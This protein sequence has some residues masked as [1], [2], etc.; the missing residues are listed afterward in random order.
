[1]PPPDARGQSRA[2]A[3]TPPAVPAGR[4]GP[5]S[6]P[7]S[8]RSTTPYQHGDPAGTGGSRA[9]RLRKLLI[10]VAGNV[11]RQG[12]QPRLQA[13][14]PYRP[15]H[16]QDERIIHPCQEPSRS[17]A[18]RRPRR[19]FR[20]HVHVEVPADNVD[21][22]ASGHAPAS[23]R[24]VILVPGHA[25]VSRPTGAPGT[26]HRTR[27]HRLRSRTGTHKPAPRPRSSN[28]P[29]HQ[30]RRDSLRDRVCLG[31]PSC[32]GI[33]GTGSSGT[34]HSAHDGRIPKQDGRRKRGTSARGLAWARRLP[35]RPR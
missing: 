13:V 16:L 3:A 17:P 25:P 35:R 33:P 15:V 24:V 19:T 29:Y 11:R 21:I 31:F 8:S 32:D 2:T 12:R 28:L 30:P 9:Y 23:A 34:V 14:R 1:M 18:G 10:V 7:G 26:R 6:T 27:V 22:P 5:P 20:C 4:S